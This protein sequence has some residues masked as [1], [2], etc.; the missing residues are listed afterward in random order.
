MIMVIIIII[1]SSI[2]AY[3]R[4]CD[5]NSVPFSV[6]INLLRRLLSMKKLVRASTEKERRYNNN[7]SVQFNSLLLVRCINSQKANYRCS[8]KENKIINI[9]K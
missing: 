3:Y 1:M 4:S 5:G 6:I 2:Y 9:T 8:T 7:N